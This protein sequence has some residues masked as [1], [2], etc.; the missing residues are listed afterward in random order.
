VG[1]ETVLVHLLRLGYLVVLVFGGVH[2]SVDWCWSLWRPYGC[3]GA[4]VCFVPVTC[5]LSGRLCRVR[6]LWIFWRN[7]AMVNNIINS[8][9][10]FSL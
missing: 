8:N 6:G 3:D 5:V 10:R 7:G 9:G 1:R 2:P 4:G